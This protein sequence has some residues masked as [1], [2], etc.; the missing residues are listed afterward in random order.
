[1]LARKFSLDKRVQAK[2]AHSTFKRLTP[3]TSSFKVILDVPIDANLTLV[4]SSP[5][6][7]DHQ[8]VVEFSVFESTDALPV[9][10][11][12]IHI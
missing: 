11:P 3:S 5:S 7:P 4:V 2:S 10:V 12:S 1:M 6:P 8:I 9:N